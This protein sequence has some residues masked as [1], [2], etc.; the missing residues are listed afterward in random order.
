MKVSRFC[1]EMHSPYCL[2]I[3]KKRNSVFPIKLEIIH[4]NHN[5]YDILKYFRCIFFSFT[6]ILIQQQSIIIS[7]MDVAANKKSTESRVPSD[8]VEVIASKLLRQPPRKTWLTVTEYL[9]HN[10]LLYVPF[11]VITIMSFPHSWFITGFVSKVTR[12][13]PLVDQ[14]LLTL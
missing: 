3:E 9:C 7:L 12:R 13:G 10:W 11:V 1:Y 8:K 6:R 4:E 2:P 5:L 14:K